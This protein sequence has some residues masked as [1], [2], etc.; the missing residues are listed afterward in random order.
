MSNFIAKRL[1]V[2]SSRRERAKDEISRVKGL[3]K[4][5][6]EIFW[7]VAPEYYFAVLTITKFQ[8]ILSHPLY[9]TVDQL[10]SDI[11]PQLVTML[12]QRPFYQ[13]IPMN[14]KNYYEYMQVIPKKT[15]N[16]NNAFY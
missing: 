16:L 14:Y 6:I 8:I 1:Y 4:V 11:L 12:G 13:N 2:I 15:Y 5:L 7:P 3:L 10:G 9:S